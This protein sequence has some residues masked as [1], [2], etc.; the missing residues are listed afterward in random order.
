MVMSSSVKWTWYSTGTAETETA[1][2]KRATGSSRAR[3]LKRIAF[4]S[5]LLGIK[6]WFEIVRANLLAL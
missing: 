1:I 6:N 4:M 3:M 2:A 5:H